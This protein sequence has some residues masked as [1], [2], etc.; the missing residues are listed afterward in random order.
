LQALN[1]LRLPKSAESLAIAG[2]L[3]VHP[4]MLALTGV[5]MAVRLGRFRPVA[6]VIWS[7]TAIIV[8]YLVLIFYARV[9]YL[10]AG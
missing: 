5:I 7:I 9:T 10:G 2:G 1:F 6:R 3:F 4:V 8:V